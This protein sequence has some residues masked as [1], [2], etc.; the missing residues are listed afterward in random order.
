MARDSTRRRLLGVLADGVPRSALDLI[1][2]TGLGAD[3]VYASL[4]RCW[5]RGFVLRSERPIFVRRRGRGSSG[6]NTRGYYLY[7]L[8]PEGVDE[9]L[10]DGVRF[11]GFNERY[12]D[13]RGGGSQSRAGLILEFLRRHRDRAFFSSEIYQALKDMGVKRSDVMANV[14]RFQRR[15]LVYVRGYK[16]DEGET[17]FK[18]GYLITWID[19]DKPREKALEEAIRRTEEALRGRAHPSA[20]ME[21]IMR[22][23]DIIIEH[24]KLKTLVSY[25]YIERALNCSPYKV[26]YALQRALQLYQELKEVKLFDAY[27]YYY[28]TSLK[29]RE[30]E[31]A[32]EMK[33]NYI[34]KTKGR[35]NRIGHNWEACAEWFIDH[36]TTG[37]RFWTQQHRNKMDPKRITLHLIKP[38][39]G[40]RRAA[41]V[42]RVW[43]V[44]P[45]IFAPSI[46][47]V[48]SC[49]W[50][51]VERRHIDDFLEVLRWSKEFGVDTPEGRAIKQG[52][53][54]VFAASAFNPRERVRFKDGT[55]IS[56]P[57]YAARMNIQ[58]LKA[59]DFNKKL[60]ERGCTR[61]TVQRICRIARDEREVR[62]ILEAIWKNPEKELEILKEIERKNKDLYEFEKL[63]EIS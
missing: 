61:A 38:V 5:R 1:R 29:G 44:S 7:L 23:R 2:A 20:L 6:P 60:R 22:I 33:K 13:P 18:W 59:S 53:V 14:R 50:G 9:L 52:V 36:F 47:Y 35:A 63:L 30:L 43:E 16:S 58:L 45:S 41:E 34:R 27:R 56:L 4:Y 39:G 40:R 21:R 19:Q 28:H 15:G 3:A 26:E 55:E 57:E 31:E 51:L 49:K 12:L 48:L 46:T 10:L 8:R 25:T 42:D 17:P 11:V 54:G 37:A 32:I 62:E 24:S